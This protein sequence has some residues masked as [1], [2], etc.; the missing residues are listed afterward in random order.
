MLKRFVLFLIQGYRNSGG[1]KRWFGIECNFE[2]TC[3]AYT[4]KAINSL[5]I[6]EGI[7]LGFNRIRRCNRRDCICKCIDPFMEER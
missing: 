5:G 6:V 7:R 4:Y 2:P 3:S 1:S